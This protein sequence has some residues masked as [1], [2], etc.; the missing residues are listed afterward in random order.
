MGTT[1]RAA[2][3]VERRVYPIDPQVLF[4]RIT[5]I[6]QGN[7]MAHSND[8]EDRVQEALD[9]FQAK[10]FSSLQEAAASLNIPR[11]T[12]GHRRAGRGTQAKVAKTQQLLTPH[13]E[14]ALVQ[15][16][17]RTSAMGFPP[18]VHAARSMAAVII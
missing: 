1:S 9:L 16:I 14:Q 11:S 8:K 4:L 5:T 12:L 18:P 3:S 7:I 10:E 17:L 13:E 15:Y 2:P 6:N